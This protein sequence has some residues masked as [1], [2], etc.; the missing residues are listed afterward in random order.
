M[1]LLFFAKNVQSL[2]KGAEM[3]TNNGKKIHVKSYFRKD[4]TK[5]KSHYRSVT[6]S[7]DYSEETNDYED[8]SIS[9]EAGALQGGVSMA[10][11]PQSE[12]EDENFASKM[13][14]TFGQIIMNSSEIAEQ[15]VSIA[16]EIERQTG[17]ENN[18]S[19]IQFKPQMDIVVTELKKAQQASE[20]LQEQ[21]LKQISNVKNKEEFRQLSQTFAKQKEVNSQTRNAINRV[22]YAIQNNDY[23]TAAAELKN[24]QKLQNVLQYSVLS[25][26]PIRTLTLKVL[27]SPAFEEIKM[28]PSNVKQNL[29]EFLRTG[30]HDTPEVEKKAIDAGM[31]IKKVFKGYNDAF[32]LWKA[33]ANQFKSSNRYIQENGFLVNRVSD[34]PPYLQSYV[35]NKLQ[36]QI[37]VREARGLLLRADSSLSK[38]IAQSPEIKNFIIKNARE[39]AQY[40]K[41]NSSINFT[42][43]NNLHL[44]L[45]HADILNAHFDSQGNFNAIIADTYDFNKNDPDWKVEW[46]YNVQANNIIE[47]FYVLCIIII[48]KP[49]LIKI[50][51]LE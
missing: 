32:E 43:D 49:D 15:G 8:Y 38:D 4:N 12:E 5:V 47:N 6:N 28:I 42:G 36:S 7:S 37:G 9:P 29:K 22:E 17:F 39:L 30:L 19:A 2:Q 13:L 26:A 14:G 50:M 34:L 48:P 1:S 18:L 16:E 51:T 11:F 45:G 46:A 35:R 40:Q 24:Y 20:D 23:K 3:T 25:L 41:I 31:I 10:V 33:A 27:K 44:S 21:N